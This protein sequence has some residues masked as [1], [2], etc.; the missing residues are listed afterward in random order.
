MKIN[1]TQISPDQYK[2][3]KS[4]VPYDQFSLLDL[5][6]AQVLEATM[7][8]K[9]DK[10]VKFLLD[11][12]FEKRTV[13]SC[14]AR[15]YKPEELVGLKVIMVANLAYATFMG[16]ESQGMILTAL[17]SRHEIPQLQELPPGTV[18]S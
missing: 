17:D 11:V 12:G 3:L 8:P 7:V 4:T 15:S 13:V 1:N 6:V 18:V 14:V 10:M 16:I 5:R 2:P 9:S